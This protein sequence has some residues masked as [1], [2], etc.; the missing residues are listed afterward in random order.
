MRTEDLERAALL[1]GAVGGPDDV[2]GAE[3]VGGPG[4]VL[5]TGHQAVDEMA[6]GC[7]VAFDVNLV[8]GQQGDGLAGAAAVQVDRLQRAVG[9]QAEASGCAFHDG[10]VERPLGPGVLR[11]AH[12]EMSRRPMQPPVKRSESVATSSP[13]V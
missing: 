6:L 11:G 12:Q 3:G 4:L 8:V 13:S 9:Q 1:G 2:H 7:G 5:G 10:L